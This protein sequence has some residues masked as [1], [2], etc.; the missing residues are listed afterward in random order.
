MSHIVKTRFAGFLRGLFRRSDNDQA[1][2]LPGD[3][4]DS[5]VSQEFVAAPEPEPAAA[6]AS[7]AADRGDELEMPLGPV[8]EK[9]PPDLR[10]KMVRPISEFAQA[11]L[12]VPLATVLSQLA[13]GAV[14][15]PFGTLR[16][17]VPGLFRVGGE[18]DDLAVTLPLNE[19]LRRLNP[20]LLSRSHARRVVTVSDQIPGPF[21]GGPAAFTPVVAPVSP[22]PPSAR[23]APPA[24]ASAAPSVRL[25][26]V[27]PPPPKAPAPRPFQTEE[28]LSFVGGK[29]DAT[30]AASRP[31]ERPRVTIAP[32][33]NSTSARP[34]ESAGSTPRTA[35][36]PSAVLPVPLAELAEKWPE[37]MRAELAQ[38]NLAN[39]EVALPMDLLTVALRR[40]RVVF[41]W[42]T[43]RMWVKPTP[44]LA[45]SA[46]DNLELTLPLKVLVPRFLAHYQPPRAGKATWTSADVPD[47][48]LG[49]APRAASLPFASPPPPAEMP[50]AAPVVPQTPE[51]IV[52][53]AATVPPPVTTV[54]APAPI[55][56]PRPR[57]AE[58]L[59]SPMDARHLQTNSRPAGGLEAPQMDPSVV[60]RLERPAA[61]GGT[62]LLARRAT[63]REIVERARAL[64]GVAGALVT[65]PDGLPVASQVP[66]ETDAEMLAAFL[67]QIFERVTQSAVEL[68]MGE[69]SH[70][71]FTV[72][73]VPWAIFRVHVFRDSTIYFAAFGHAGQTL[74]DAPL[75][76]LAAE[77]DR[78]QR[79]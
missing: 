39:A 72:G 71:S 42:R 40:G 57:P 45:P 55:I 62:D 37:A 8:L 30:G 7:P 19:V 50:D 20:K 27:T 67:P 29:G 21:G 10:V 17:A 76:A 66:A 1:A 32:A 60:K 31:P 16:A 59:A 51:P 33:V 5:D 13:T 47:L 2:T 6:P 54:P 4:F 11:S 46:R 78:K 43:L 14:R 73:G 34:P 74:P 58:A 3:T 9:L 56:E 44:M 18:F 22:T 49:T 79:P 25:A 35:A 64:P 53:R 61:S 23:P 41:P 38:L 52:N 70:L 28:P 48:V 77:L 65:L 24:A 36:P 26:S 12:F 69:L 15:I 75:A 63:P 68:Q